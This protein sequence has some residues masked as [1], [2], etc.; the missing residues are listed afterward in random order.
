MDFCFY[1]VDGRWGISLGN[2]NVNGRVILI[3]IVFKIV[4]KNIFV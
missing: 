4:S 2:L 1:C 3:N